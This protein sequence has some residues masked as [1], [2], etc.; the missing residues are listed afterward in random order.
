[1][2]LLIDGDMRSPEIHEIFDTELGPGLADVL[3]G[4]CPV[5]EAIETGFSEKLHVLTAGR[6]TTSPHQLLGRGEF[7]A[8]VE[9][10][11]TMY[12]H[13]VIDTPPILPASEAL[14]M[15]RAADMAVLCVRR[16][17]SRLDQVE[18]ANR[19]MT[20]AGVNTAG[21]VLNGI[22]HQHYAYKYGSYYYNRSL[23]PQSTELN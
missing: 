16:D 5:E 9:K 11:S 2:T 12:G 4:E 22:P 18:E 3:R 8:L 20:G 23:P 13:I 19:R 7:R 10:L 1:M 17:Y 15:A 21:A 6:L 14:I